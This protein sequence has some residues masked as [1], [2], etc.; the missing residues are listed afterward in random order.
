M[1]VPNRFAKRL[2]PE[3]KRRRKQEARLGRRREE[4]PFAE[5]PHFDLPAGAKIVSSETVGAAR[6]LNFSLQET[7]DGYHLQVASVLA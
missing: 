2:Q 5:K 4:P 3:R 7:G 6:C 1:S